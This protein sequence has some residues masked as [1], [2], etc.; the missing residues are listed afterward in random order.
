MIIGDT[1][2]LE[3]YENFEYFNWKLSLFSLFEKS[4]FENRKENK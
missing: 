2:T 1:N 3:K 4:Q